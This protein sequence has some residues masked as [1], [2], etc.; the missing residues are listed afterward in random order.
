M[1]FNSLWVPLGFS[2][3]D[4]ASESDAKSYDLQM[5]HLRLTCQNQKAYGYDIRVW[6][7]PKPK[8]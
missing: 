2:Y 4:A 1:K 3:T 5:R 7:Q 6:C 8:G